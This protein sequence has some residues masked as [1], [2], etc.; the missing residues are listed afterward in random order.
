MPTVPAACFAEPTMA[1]SLGEI[2]GKE[3][4]WLRLNLLIQRD[5]WSITNKCREIDALEQAVS[6]SLSTQLS[7][8][9]QLLCWYKDRY[10]R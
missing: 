3:S 6:S 1:V 5:S 4:N 2:E 9:F 8:A 7:N 10:S